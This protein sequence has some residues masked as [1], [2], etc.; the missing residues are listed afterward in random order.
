M[1][2][3]I[4]N[5]N[6]ICVI[7]KPTGIDSEK[8]LPSLLSVQLECEI[9]P[10]HRLD[11]GVSGLMVYA[12]TKRSAAKLSDDIRTKKLLKEYFCVV[13]GRP[14]K[15]SDT[16]KDLLYRDRKS[17][18]TFVVSRER[19]GVKDASLEYKLIDS[20]E[21]ENETLSLLR[22]LL[23]TGRTHQI[24]V[25]FASRKLSLL[26]D[27]RYGGNKL[28]KDISLFSCHLKFDHPKTNQPLDFKLSLPSEFPW[29]LFSPDDSF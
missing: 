26:G 5:D 22:V 16:L 23:H 13:S 14:E 27:R 11:K 10:V 8:D 1:I 21:Y 20:I 24:R 28:T 2:E 9:Y 19:K 15:D 6:E 17:G 25:Q 7:K 29:N 18:K 3:I 12:K 4:Y